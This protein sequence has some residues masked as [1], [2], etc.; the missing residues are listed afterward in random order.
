MNKK[1]LL[2]LLVACILLFWLC[3]GFFV[4]QPIGAIPEGATVW[5]IRLGTKL[6]FVSSPDGMLLEMGQ[7]V[8][9]LGRAM[10]LGQMGDVVKQKKIIS[11][12]YSKALY[13]I[14]TGGK[15]FEK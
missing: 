13:L 6:S 4:I 8:T 14:S 10:V 11:F 5:Y 3:T 1:G 7:G 2:V 15:E 9:L 12:P